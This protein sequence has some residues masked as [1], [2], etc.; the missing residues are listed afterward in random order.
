MKDSTKKLINQE[1]FRIKTGNRFAVLKDEICNIT[2][3]GQEKI[4]LIKRKGDRE[5]RKS[6]TSET[7]NKKKLNKIYLEMDFLIILD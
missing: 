5:I 2:V 4:L 7:E 1:L 6:P 3:T